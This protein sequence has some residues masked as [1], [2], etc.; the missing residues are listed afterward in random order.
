M[1]GIETTRVELE[2]LT[3]PETSIGV[4]RALDSRF[5]VV[6]ERV[7]SPKWRVK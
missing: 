1:S 5:K 2:I 3:Q 4:K 6:D 7:M